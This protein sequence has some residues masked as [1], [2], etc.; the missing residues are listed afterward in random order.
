MN[1][2]S[3][4]LDDFIEGTPFT[5]RQALTQGSTGVIAIPTGIQHDNIIHQANA[6]TSVYHLLG[7]F[8]VTSWLRTEAHNKA[9]GGAPKSVHLIGLATDFIPSH[10][11][12][13]EAR[14]KIR[15]SGVYPGRGEEG[16]LTWVHLD[17]SSTVW[18]KP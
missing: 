8:T 13:E 16:T 11:T 18:F 7:G 17:L 4:P 14:V 12:P 6:L 10:M 5:W 15:A 1:N 3:D 9:V 2:A